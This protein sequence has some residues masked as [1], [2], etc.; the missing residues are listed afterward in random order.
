MGLK[1]IYARNRFSILD[2]MHE[3]S[4]IVKTRKRVVIYYA[5][6]DIDFIKESL[7]VAHGSMSYHTCRR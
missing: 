5:G 2:R 1:G 4:N 6:A 7:E 3:E